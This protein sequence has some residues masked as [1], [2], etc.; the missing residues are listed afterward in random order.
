MGP[1]PQI[2]GNLIIFTEEI[3]KTENLIFVQREF[4]RF[5]ILNQ[6]I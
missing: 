6:L 1:N 2:P 3:I 4:T 5:V